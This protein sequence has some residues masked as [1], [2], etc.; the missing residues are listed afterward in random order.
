MGNIKMFWGQCWWW[1]SL[2][3]NIVRA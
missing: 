1:K 3:P 2:V